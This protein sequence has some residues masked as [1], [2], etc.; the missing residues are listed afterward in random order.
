MVGIEFKLKSKS[1][2]YKA[3]LAKLTRNV[4]ERDAIKELRSLYN[5]QVRLPI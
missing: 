3:K 1:N 4:E 2:E 5:N